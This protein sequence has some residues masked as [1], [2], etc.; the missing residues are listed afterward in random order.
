MTYG[1]AREQRPM[2]HGG[3][4][5][6]RYVR[7]GGVGVPDREELTVDDVAGT[8]RAWRSLAAAA[9]H[10]G[11]KLECDTLTALSA[12]ADRARALGAGAGRRAPATDAAEEVVILDGLTVEIGQETELPD[13]WG[14]LVSRLRE[15]LD[16]T[17]G[18]PVA[19]VGLEVATADKT[20]RLVHLGTEALDLDL[21]AL[22]LSASLWGPDLARLG[23]W[24]LPEPPRA[25]PRVSAKP[26]WSL[27]LDFGTGFEPGP[28]RR[29]VAQA[30]FVAFDGPEPVPVAVTAVETF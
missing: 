26:G 8:V 12:A 11:G 16:Q 13:A 14:V 1:P 27:P 28:G 4:T 5:E 18:M 23:R 15:L 2:R 19:A 21:G 3:G 17:V 6:I 24:R 22:A 7:A 29:L 25:E 30:T 20:A 9:G 10:F